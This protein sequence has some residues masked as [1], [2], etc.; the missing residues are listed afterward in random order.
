MLKKALQMIAEDNRYLYHVTFLKDLDSIISEG[1]GF[2]GRG[3]DFYADRSQ[4]KLFFTEF[5][6]VSYWMSK[7]E[8]RANAETDHPEE[9]WVPVV[10]RIDEAYFWNDVDLQEDELGSKDSLSTAV[11]VEPTEYF[12]KIDAPELEIWDG[13]SWVPLDRVDSDSMLQRALAAAEVEGE[14]EESWY[15]MDFDVFMPKT[16]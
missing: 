7:L 12:T 16:E 9:G 5:S 8:D 10:L 4:D 14:G 3:G 6:G 1:L 15:N 11:Y 2:G 13:A